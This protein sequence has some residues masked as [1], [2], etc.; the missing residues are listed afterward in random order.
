MKGYDPL[1]A[2][3]AAPR[4]PLLAVCLP[5]LPAP[6]TLSPGMPPSCSSPSSSTSTLA[7]QIPSTLPV[8]PAWP[9]TEWRAPVTVQLHNGDKQDL[10]LGAYYTWQITFLCLSVSAPNLSVCERPESGAE[11]GVQVWRVHT[12]KHTRTH[13]LAHT[14][15]YTS[16]QVLKWMFL[17]QVPSTTSIPSSCIFMLVRV[18]YYCV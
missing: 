18:T 11:V 9:P 15:M 2:E 17:S 3:A 16:R 1:L 14:Y 8:S 5:S 12:H 4:Y 13:T 6:L 10:E 7:S